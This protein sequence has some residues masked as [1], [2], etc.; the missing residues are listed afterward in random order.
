M[1]S[2]M[3][4]FCGLLLVTAIFAL[5][6]DPRPAEDATTF[7]SEEIDTGVERVPTRPY[8]GFF[9]DMFERMRRQ[10]LELMGAVPRIG[11][12]NG[13]NTTSVT[14]IID[15]HK[16]TI[17][18]TV[19]SSGDGENVASV[20]KV[21]VVDVRPNTDEDGA[22]SINT[23]STGSVETI[24]QSNENEITGKYQQKRKV[25]KM[26]AFDMV[27]HAG[28]EYPSDSDGEGKRE[29][30]RSTETIEDVDNDIETFDGDI[31][32]FDEPDS[33]P[34]ETFDDA[35]ESFGN[36]IE[37]NEIE[38]VDHR[39]KPIYLG[40]DLRVNEIAAA[41]GWTPHP[42]SEFLDVANPPRDLSRDTYINELAA[43]EGRRPHPDAETFEPLGN[44]EGEK[45]LSGD[46]L[47][48]ELGRVPYNPDAEFIVDNLP[49]SR[50]YYR[51]ENR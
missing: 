21:R 18:E 51:T 10:M 12:P 1:Q 49:N 17:N 2:Y 38:P 32:T 9:E 15:G 6:A 41:Q 22:G 23:D 45:D 8:Y 5:P 28:E 26:E 35:I 31:E 34:M 33:K 19:Y 11:S 29:R 43:M 20:V 24:E 4:L 37:D 30:L 7:E 27:N 40:N 3:K 46:T 48:N 14:K 16:V 25:V 50:Y 13:G 36:S 44:L 39:R 42:D 47:V